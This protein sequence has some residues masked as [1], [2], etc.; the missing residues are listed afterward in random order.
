MPDMITKPECTEC[1]LKQFSQVCRMCGIDENDPENRPD[2][3]RKKI[4]EI[5]TGVTPPQAAAAFFSYISEK[6]GIEDPYKDIKIASNNAAMSLYPM[7]KERISSSD[8][9][10]S[11]A[12]ALAI[13]GNLIDFGA[14]ADLDLSEALTEILDQPLFDNIKNNG[15]FNN[16]LFRLDDFYEDLKSVDNITYLAD[17]AGEIVFDRVFIETILAEFPGKNITLAVRGGPALNDVLVEDAENVGLD[18]ITEVI[19]SGAA[20]PGTV[21]SSCSDMFRNKLYSSD[22]IISKGQGNYE[23]LSGEELPP[24]WFL[25]KIKCRVV[26]AHA[27]GPEGILVLKKNASEVLTT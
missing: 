25:F 27:K 17:N 20:I 24:T 12:L 23:T 15:D 9:P 26:A 6:T 2:Q 19:S 13:A 5:S 22:L 18:S 21:I 4:V 10:F 3:M 8:A 11:E 16:D 1:L 7:L 14:R